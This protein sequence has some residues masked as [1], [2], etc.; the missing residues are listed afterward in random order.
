VTG[1]THK[2]LSALRHDPLIRARYTRFVAAMVY[3]E[4]LAFD[5]AMH[6]VGLMVD[7]AWP[8]AD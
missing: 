1:E 7:E 2:A 6:T 5:A 8:L 3:G 4:P